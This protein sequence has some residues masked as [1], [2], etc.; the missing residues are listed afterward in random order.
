MLE[1][2]FTINQILKS[3]QNFASPVWCLRPYLASIMTD[4]VQS[5]LDS[6]NIDSAFTMANSNSF[7]SPYEILP[8]A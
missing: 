8:I 7:L 3:I 4:D 6:L 1:M 2:N 5:N